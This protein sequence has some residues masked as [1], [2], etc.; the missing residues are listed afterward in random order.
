M[1][2]SAHRKARIRRLRVR[3]PNRADHGQGRPR[4]PTR[5]M[6]HYISD[7][8]A[9]PVSNSRRLVH[10]RRTSDDSSSGTGVRSESEVRQI[11]ASV[12]DSAAN[13]ERRRTR[14]E[15]RHR[16]FVDPAFTGM[17]APRQRGRCWRT[18][19]GERLRCAASGRVLVIH[20]ALRPHRSATVRNRQRACRGSDRVRP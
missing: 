9:A 1:A 13:A 7:M 18:T 6:S 4:A 19:F 8:V 10:L 14:L 17:V 5:A 15:L 11:G 2:E 3:V 16:G 20:P 12:P